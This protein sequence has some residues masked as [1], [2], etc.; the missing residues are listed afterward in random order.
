M[1]QTVT[2]LLPNYNGARFLRESIP[3]LLRQ[4]YQHFQLIV[5]DNCSTDESAAV[6]S[7]F[8]DNRISFV[9]HL[10]HVPVAGSF[11]RA[12]ELVDTPF[13][14]LCA[15]D[16]VYEPEW[17][18]TMIGLLERQPDA[19][20]ACCKIDSADID[21]HVYLAPY[22]RYKDSFWPQAEPALFAR[23]KYVAGFSKGCFLIITSGVFRASALEKIGLLDEELAF[24]ADW[25]YL[26]RGLLAGFTIIGTHR[27]LVHYRRHPNMTT[28]SLNADLSRFHSELAMID[29]MTKAAFEQGVINSRQPDYRIVRNTLLHELAIYL[30]VRKYAYADK[31]LT[32]GIEKIP[33]FKGTFF[34][35]IAWVACRLGRN[36]G[37]A[38]LM[39]E[40]IYL[41]L[42]LAIREKLLP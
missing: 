31:L 7:G 5:V 38:L 33:R 40:G 18:G 34:H 29:W 36:G 20:F 22:E 27:R 41:R 8:A 6:V 3:A 16:E 42:R 26:I 32:F 15:V 9:P 25:Q 21:G 13:Y 23:D 4:T 1:N 35:Y 30:T 12:Q 39:A 19:F 10:E 24:A 14:A 37:L 11:K 2:L 17:L 28:N